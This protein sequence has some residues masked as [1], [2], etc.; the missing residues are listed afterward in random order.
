MVT[1]LAAALASLA[2]PAD[3]L[4]AAGE[5]PD[6]KEVYELIRLHGAGVTDAELNRA[7]VAGL[8]TVLGPKVSLVTGR[9]PTNA[10]AGLPAVS[11][12]RV[13][14]GSVAYFRIS[15]V[16]DGLAQEVSNGYRRLGSTN[17][18]KGVVLDLRYTGGDDY[19]A[20]A[21]AADLFATKAEPLLNWGAGTVSSVAKTNAIRVPAVVLVNR[22]TASAAEALAAAMREIGAGLILGGRTAGAAMITHDFPLADGE[23]LRIADA[24]VKLGDGSALPAKGVKPDI[25]VA[26][27]PEDERIYFADAFVLPPRTNLLAG[28]RLSTANPLSPTNLASSRNRL[29]EAELVREHKQ[30]SDRDAEDGEAPAPRQVQPVEPLVSDPALARALDLLKGL[31]VVH[32]DHF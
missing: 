19:S 30:G 21:A 27:S 10:P 31:A 8:L 23:Q 4:A 7:A 20:A 24:P 28:A 13:F 29:N 16:S 22:Q 11:S 12:A 26:V 6:F 14:E 2:G 18:L 3:A 5:A 1:F 17:I 32:Q 9:P 25:E 15:R